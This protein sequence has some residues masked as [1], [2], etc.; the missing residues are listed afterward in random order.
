MA[1]LSQGRMGTVYLLLGL[2]ASNASV[3][4]RARQAAKLWHLSGMYQ[5]AV[6]G[7]F[8]PEPRAQVKPC[9]SWGALRHNQGQPVIELGG[10]SPEGPRAGQ[11]VRQFSE[12]LPK[13]GS[14][15]ASNG[16]SRAKRN[17]EWG[18][19]AS[20]RWRDLPCSPAAVSWENRL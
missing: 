11:A 3:C 19:F 8:G 20:E 16:T 6:W 2:G 1:M 14:Q 12:V 15:L 13:E 9:S 17:G 18:R 10:P 4:D 5:A 7:R